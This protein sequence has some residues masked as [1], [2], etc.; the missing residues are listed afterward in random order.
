MVFT[1]KPHYESP[2]RGSIPRA[3][4]TSVSKVVG[5]G[6]GG[7]YH[8][9]RKWLEPKD[10]FEGLASPGFPK[11]VLSHPLPPFER[12]MS[13]TPS[14]GTEPDRTVV[15]GWVW[16][17]IFGAGLGRLM[18]GW[19]VFY[20]PE[21]HLSVDVFFHWLSWSFQSQ[22]QVC[23]SHK[24]NEPAQTD[25]THGTAIGRT[26]A[27]EVDPPKQPPPQLAVLKAVRTGSP[28]RVVFGCWFSCW[29]DV[30]RIEVGR[31][32]FDTA[33]FRD[34][35]QGHLL[36]FEEDQVM[37]LQSIPRYLARNGLQVPG[38]GA[39]NGSSHTFWYHWSPKSLAKMCSHGFPMS[40]AVNFRS[41]TSVSLV[42]V[43]HMSLSFQG[44]DLTRHVQAGLVPTGH[45][46]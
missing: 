5:V 13:S 29:S 33:R 2:I 36:R 28:R 27:P 8:L 18:T 17:P 11:D 26:A 42:R 41:W 30:N 15:R 7:S 21:P 4:T 46:G 25:R 43:C 40:S 22:S 12:V 34:I 31:R 20:V 14:V 45:K 9:L 38:V 1:T 23:L 37:F 19:V 6:L 3:P 10:I 39:R 24:T 16:L 44:W 35:R 32:R